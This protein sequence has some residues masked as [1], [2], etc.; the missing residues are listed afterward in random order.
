MEIA[1]YD[2]ELN[3]LVTAKDYPDAVYGALHLLVDF[4]TFIISLLL[5]INQEGENI[6]C[7]VADLNKIDNTSTLALFLN[8]DDANLRL[9]AGLLVKIR[10]TRKA[11]NELNGGVGEEPL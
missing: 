9:L 8:A 11:M 10:E 1:G 6:E 7:N 5:E 2:D 3:E 4:E